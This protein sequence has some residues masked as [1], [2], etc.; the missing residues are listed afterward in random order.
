MSDMRFVMIGIV[1]VF[2]GVI[3]LGVFGQDYQAAT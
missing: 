1:L 3:V 2:V